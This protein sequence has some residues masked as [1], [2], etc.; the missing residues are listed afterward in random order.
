MANALYD[1]YKAF[2]INHLAGDVIKAMLVDTAE[3]A[4][5]AAHEFLS[6]VPAAARVATSAALTSK[7]TTAGV[8]DAADAVYALVTGDVS[9]AVIIYAD[10][11]VEATSRLIVFLDTMGGL[12]ITPNGQNINQGWDAAGIFAL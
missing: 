2:L 1:T 9:E 7:T 3:Y 6:D 4:F 5:S 8:F 11:G 10:T 12:P